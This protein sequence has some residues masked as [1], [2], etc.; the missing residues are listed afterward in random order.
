LKE[1]T[2]KINKKDAVLYVAGFFLSSKCYFPNG[3]SNRTIFGIVIFSATLA[4]VHQPNVGESHI[5]RLEF[6]GYYLASK[7]W[8]QWHNGCH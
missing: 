7:E 2:F 8:G 6:G 4:N 3:T 1:P 5:G